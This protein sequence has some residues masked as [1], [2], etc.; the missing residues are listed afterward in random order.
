MTKITGL[1]YS[2]ARFL[3]YPGLM[4]GA[5]FAFGASASAQTDT[6]DLDVSAEVTASCTI[7]TSPLAFG[8]YDPVV[9]HAASPLEQTGGVT[10]TCTSGAATTVTLGQGLS[11]DAGSTDAVPVRRMLSGADFLSY[12]LYSDSGRTTAWG[13]TAGAGVAH[14]GTGTATALTV[15]GRIPAAQNVPAGSYVDTVVATVTF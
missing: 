10:V 2:L 4:A 8:S 5:L 7:T 13:N 15:Y 14:T 6:A 9:T 12:A 1:N 11:A 3:A